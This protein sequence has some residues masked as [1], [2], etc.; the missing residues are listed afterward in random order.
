[1]KRKKKPIEIGNRLQE[2]REHL[3]YSR[4]QMAL[5]CEVT[6]GG[7]AKYERGDYL[8][9]LD[10]LE[11]LSKKFDTSMDWLLF[12]KGPMSFKEKEPEEKK[13]PQ[14][15]TGEKKT[16]EKFP[17]LEHVTPDVKQLLDYMALDP[18]LRY[19]VLVYFYK[20]KKENTQP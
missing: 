3:N 4:Q 13:E 19:E 9:K 14:G 18:L 20:Y 7:Y 10:T 15:K 6:K 16:E 12:N 5:H 1:M 2:L 8:P 17:G 11:Q